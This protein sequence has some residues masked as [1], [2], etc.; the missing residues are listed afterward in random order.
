MFLHGPSILEQEPN[1][2]VA[3]DQTRVVHDEMER[4]KEN[5]SGASQPQKAPSSP[6]Y[7]EILARGSPYNKHTA[8]GLN[9]SSLAKSGSTIFG[10]V[11]DIPYVAGSWCS[12]AAAPL[13]R[14]RVA[15]TLSHHGTQVGLHFGR[16]N[17]CGRISYNSLHRPSS[18]A[19]AIK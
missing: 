12:I 14:V 2:A 7:G 13:V 15:L 10:K 6:G 18:R 5:T 3:E 19:T 16:N 1:L 9:G 11:P 17:K 4:K 8:F